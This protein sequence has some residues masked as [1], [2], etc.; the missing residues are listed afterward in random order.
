MVEVDR[1]STPNNDH[2]HNQMFDKFSVEIVNV[3]LVIDNQALPWSISNKS[4]LNQSCFS[5]K[6]IT[7][8]E[9]KIFW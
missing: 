7:R 4:D 5:S 3:Q 1:R 6:Y 8:E 2:D 9:W